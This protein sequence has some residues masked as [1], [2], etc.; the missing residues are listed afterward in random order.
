MKNLFGID[1]A[2]GVIDGA[3]F[4]IRQTDE[5]IIKRQEEISEKL[6][7]LE[8]SAQTPMWSVI[9]RAICALVAVVFAVMSIVS[10]AKVGFDGF[11]SQGG[12]MLIV[13]ICTMLIF[14]ALIFIERVRRR[15]DFDSGEMQ[16]QL[17]KA[18]ALFNESK[19]SLNIP[20]GCEEIT[21]LA[22][23]YRKKGDKIVNVIPFGSYVAIELFL[24]EEDGKIC[25]ADA[26]SVLALDEK[27][28]KCIDVF[29]H[30][31]NVH[32]WTKA[33]GFGGEKYAP[34]VKINQNGVLSIKD[35]SSVQFERNGEMFE[36]VIPP[37]D[38]E[39][40]LKHFGGSEKTKAEQPAV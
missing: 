5:S 21:L 32:G 28:L 34:Y 12:W 26:A 40:L 16:A 33:E 7:K 14:F 10:I 20:D 36:I 15:E 1:E 9:A 13:A 31:V 23:L 6:Y 30:S 38:R 4:I 39:T 17:M 25:L 29:S 24:F 2:V 18:Q 27:E 37:Y 22:T 11:K 35:C 8:K 19:Q 3:G